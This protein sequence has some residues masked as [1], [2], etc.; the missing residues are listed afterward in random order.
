MSFRCDLKLSWGLIT[1]LDIFSYSPYSQ[2]LTLGFQK[3]VNSW[4]V[5][6]YNFFPILV[7]KLSS[8]FKIKHFYKLNARNRYF[9]V[10]PVVILRVTGSSNPFEAI[11]W[12]LSFMALRF[13]ISSLLVSEY[14]G[15][16]ISEYLFLAHSLIEGRKSE[17][18]HVFAYKHPIFL[19]FRISYSLIV[20]RSYSLIANP[21]CNSTLTVEWHEN[22][23]VNRKKIYLAAEKNLSF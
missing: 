7:V 5:F 1:H 19:R 17:K 8:S 3:S 6:D 22:K 11:G 13:I 21:P 4:E 23:L 16:V 20:R 12:T 10:Q 14:R 18:F 2:L 15:V 9:Q